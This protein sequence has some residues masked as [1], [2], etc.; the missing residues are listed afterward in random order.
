MDQAVLF[1]TILGMAAVTFLPRLLPFWL[2]TSRRLP[3][4]LAAWLRYVPIAVLSS[5]LL[6][7]LLVDG[8]RVDLRPDNVF[9]WAAA[10]AAL[11]A[12]KTRS[13]LASVAVGMVIVAASRCVLGL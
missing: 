7:L 10:P 3:P 13:F 8:D 11:V 6:P 1:V 5:M 9:L 2:L 4:S 12:W